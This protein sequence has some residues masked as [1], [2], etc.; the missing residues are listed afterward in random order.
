MRSTSVT[1]WDLLN[2]T[3]S[4]GIA[5]RWLG[6]RRVRGFLIHGRWAHIIPA[7]R[8]EIKALASDWFTGKV[9]LLDG[10]QAAMAELEIVCGEIKQR[11]LPACTPSALASAK[12]VPLR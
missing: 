4:D 8:N 2:A 11:G 7:Q 10:A 1:K 6:I 3:F 12:G 9:Q 5:A